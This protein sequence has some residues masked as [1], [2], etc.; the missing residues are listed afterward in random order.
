MEA[1]AEYLGSSVERPRLTVVKDGGESYSALPHAVLF[2]TRLSHGARLLYAVLQSHWWQGGECWASHATLAGQLG[3]KDR[4]LRYYL[5]ELLKAGVISERLRGHGQAKAYAPVQAATDCQ[6]KRQ[7]D[8][9]SEPN[10]QEIAS[11]AATHYQFKRQPVADRRRSTEEDTYGSKKQQGDAANA[12]PA[13]VEAPKVKSESRAKRLPEDWILTPAHIEAAGKKG[14]DAA[15]AAVEAEKFCDYHR[16]KGTRM[17]DWMAAWRTWLGN[18]VTF[19][20]R[21][22]PVVRNGSGPS[23]PP[24]A[25]AKQKSW[26][27]DD[28][29]RKK[30][31]VSTNADPKP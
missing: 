14:L 31:R 12:A 10:R 19:D 23:I 22:S 29:V 13:D 24:G 18:A 8:A 20:A 3:C 25:K 6:L 21:R 28:D 11:Q 15:R 9:A 17:L 1:R 27:T 26:W 16:A 7:E 4:M 2:D 5:T 30:W